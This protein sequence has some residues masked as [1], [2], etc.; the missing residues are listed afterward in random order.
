MYFYLFSDYKSHCSK[1]ATEVTP[2]KKVE[3]YIINHIP[4][5]VCN[6]VFKNLQ[7]YRHVQEIVQHPVAIYCFPSYQPHVAQP[8]G[9][10]LIKNTTII[11]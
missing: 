6:V 1:M 10:D 4:R 5:P 2:R 8:E 7:F 9:T 3:F 11:K